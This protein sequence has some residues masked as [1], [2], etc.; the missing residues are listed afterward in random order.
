MY[1][2]L[3]TTAELALQQLETTL[4]DRL[5]NL[6]AAHRD[7]KD[8]H[9]S[10]SLRHIEAPDQERWQHSKCEIRNDTKC[11]VQISQRNDDIHAYTDAISSLIP[12]VRN[13]LAL[14]ERHQKERHASDDSAHACSVNNPGVNALRH[15]SQQKDCK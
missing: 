1:G 12:I 7:E 4:S 8:E 9:K 6:H 5:K 3:T 15:N 11:A 13:R 2:I 10:R 14:K